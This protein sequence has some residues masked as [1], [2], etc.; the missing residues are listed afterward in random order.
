M[1]GGLGAVAGPGMGRGLAAL[2]PDCALFLAGAALQFAVVYRGVPALVA[3]GA[4]PIVAW[5]LLSAPCIFAPVIAGG[6]LLLRREPPPRSRA[7]RLRLR[8]PSAADWRWGAL[9]LL[10]LALG[11]GALFALCAA[12]G[13]DPTP[14]FSRGVR[15]LSAD[16]L[17]L[18]GL[19]ALY[20]PIN[21]LGENLV[22]RGVVLPR[23]EAVVGDRAWLLNALLWG[24]F[25]LAFGPGNLLVLLP[26]LLLVPLL[27]Q[28][29]RNTWLAVLLH[30]GLSGPGFVALALGLV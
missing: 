14:P 7:A 1:V 26:T 5:M 4:E 6:L 9:G 23:M 19:W 20:W 27:A 13:L 28:R 2:A 15:P 12:L 16:R 30:A 11:S 8:R 3:A 17:W 18:I 25:H 10:G 24:L 22:W 21:I 29:R